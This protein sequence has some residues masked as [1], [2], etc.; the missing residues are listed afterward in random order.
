[1]TRNLRVAG[2][3]M[4]P[5]VTE[6]LNALDPP[7][8]DAALVAAVR[9]C[10]RTIDEM[11]PGVRAAM[12]ANVLGPML[13]TLAALDDRKKNRLAGRPAPPNRLAKLREARAAQDAQQR[14][15]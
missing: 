1:M 8:E 15:L 4:V 14:R 2:E 10:A 5:A 11:T 7:A 3:Q 13:R 12:L 9:I 6:M